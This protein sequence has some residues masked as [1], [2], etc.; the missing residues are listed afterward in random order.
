MWA[1]PAGTC[2]RTL[3]KHPRPKGVLFDLPQAMTDAPAR[4]QALGVEDRVTIQAG[5][6]F[7]AVPPGADAYILSHPRLERRPLPHHLP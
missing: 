1:V 5:N 2:L 4:L 3:A 7:E 6:A